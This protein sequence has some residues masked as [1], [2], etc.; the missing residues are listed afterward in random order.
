MMNF[1]D[2][3]NEVNE[4]ESKEYNDLSK[5]ILETCVSQDE[6]YWLDTNYLIYVYP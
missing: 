5:A 1:E 6:V 4:E 3:E 2:H